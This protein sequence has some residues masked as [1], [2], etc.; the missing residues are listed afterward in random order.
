MN[1]P[2]PFINSNPL[3]EAATL[4][5]FSAEEIRFEPIIDVLDILFSSMAF[6]NYFINVID[7]RDFS[8]PYNSPST[9]H[10]V[11]HSPEGKD[12]N[13]LTSVLHPKDLPIFLE[14]GGKA[15]SHITSL[16]IEKKKRA[17]FNHCYRI[18]HG[19]KNEYIWLYQQHH[20][21]HIDSN[22]A[23]VYSISFITDVTH[24]LSNQLT[25]SWSVTERLDDGTSLFHIG[26]T[27]DNI[28]MGSKLFTIR[29]YEVLRLFTQ[30]YSARDVSAQL[31]MSYQTVLSHKKKILRKTNSKNI[32]EAVTF[33]LNL[34]YL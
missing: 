11:G 24:L 31:K 9:M 14:Y 16:P 10:V 28:K 12:L 6:G 20:M 5:N 1:K 8:Y 2:S 30:G 34:G 19:I 17:M 33:A 7:F 18:Y 3:Y 25:P 32:S 15:I 13:W 23:I 27:H 21:S 29:E 22:G 4:Q 26:S